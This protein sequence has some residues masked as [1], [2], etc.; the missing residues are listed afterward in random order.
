MAARVQAQAG[1]VLQ[2]FEGWLRERGSPSTSQR[3]R[4]LEAIQAGPPHFGAEELSARLSK[5]GARVSR[6]T[7]YR[8]LGSLEAAGVV[9][10]VELDADHAHY[11]LAEG[12]HHEHLVCESCGRIIEFSDA[13]VE[14][15]LAAVLREHGFRARRHLVQV[16]GTCARCSRQRE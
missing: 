10:R 16:F 6:A 11:E 8:T 9:R 15:R 7:L 13:A 1:G 5:A 14:K 3:R 4:I 12:E 2:S